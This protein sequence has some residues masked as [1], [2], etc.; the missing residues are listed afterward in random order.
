MTPIR[1]T[2]YKVW[3][4]ELHN[5]TYVKREGQWESNYVK[6]GELEISRVNVIATIVQ[7][8]ENAENNYCSLTVDDGSDTIRIKAW[9]EDTKLISKFNVG[10]IIK[11]IGK[12][13]EYNNEIY[14]MPELVKLV[15]D[16]NWILVRK[17]ELIKK[18][19]KPGNI[20]LKQEEKPEIE[21]SKEESNI[22]V[23]E[24]KLGFVDK[25]Q[26]ILKLIE[27]LDS[28]EGVDEN[29]ILIESDYTQNEVKEVLQEL[30]KEGEIYELKPGRIK[31]L[32]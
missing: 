13:K 25:R 6:I 1:N 23:H 14:L 15:D 11:I 5:G 4:A 28:E 8:Y 24:E 10:D 32:P 2:A 19:G 20:G 27:K 16:L 12:T 21:D 29:K 22:I 7:K 26:E 9:G 30:L 31:I 3:I 17:L 18:Y